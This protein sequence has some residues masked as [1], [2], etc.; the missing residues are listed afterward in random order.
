[1]KKLMLVAAFGAAAVLTACGDDSS[2]NASSNAPG[3]TVS[4]VGNS[5]I[6]TETVPPFGS[7]TTTYT[8]EGDSVKIE[9]S[10]QPEESMVLPLYGRTLDY[11]QK[12]AE[13]DCKDFY[14][15]E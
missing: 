14:T 8:V 13:D 5:V 3:C 7:N 11:Y 4:V 15:N 2:S 9:Y 10:A 6:Q 12:Q 1:M